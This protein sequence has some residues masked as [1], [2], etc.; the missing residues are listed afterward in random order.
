M[1]HAL[2]IDGENL[3]SRHADR[4]RAEVPPDCAVRQVFGDTARL[5][6][7]LAVPWLTAVHVAPGRNAADIALA[8]QAMDLA[9]SR[10]CAAFTIATSDG[11]LAS[12]VTHL[13]GLG[14][15]VTVAGEAK[16]AAPLR[17]AAHRY[18]ELPPLAEPAAAPPAA[19][20]EALPKPLVVLKGL[21]PLETFLRDL[22]MRNGP[23]GMPVTGVNP[24]ALREQ[25]TK[26]ARLPEKTWRAWF[27]A[28][29]HLFALDPKGPAARVRLAARA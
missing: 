21:N 11:G 4:I 20:P 18:A 3:S 24:V 6:G 1:M 9:L 7:W 27:S 25:G 14:R 2:L 17:E 5:N 26:I 23:D 29:P 28:R 12:L 8:V 15:H 22:V 19:A 13:R 16:T 10:G